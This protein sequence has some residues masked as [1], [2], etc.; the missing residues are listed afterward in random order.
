MWQRKSR[1]KSIFG[2]GAAMPGGGLCGN[3]IEFI[4]LD[5]FAVRAVSPEKVTEVTKQGAFPLT[6]LYSSLIR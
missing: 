4:T 5:D 1:F 2:K 3:S 6:S